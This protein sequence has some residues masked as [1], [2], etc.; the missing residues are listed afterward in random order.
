MVDVVEVEAQRAA[1]DEADVAAGL[2]AGL[3]EA[4]EA[5]RV[6]LL[7]LAV[8]QRDERALGDAR[9]E[10]LLLAHLDH[11]DARVARRGA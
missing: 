8:Q 4:A 3:E 5:Q 1:D 2:A 7:A 11:L 10:P 6:E 9:R